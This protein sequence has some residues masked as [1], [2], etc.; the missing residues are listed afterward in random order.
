MKKHALIVLIF[1][2]WA[3]AATAQQE[4]GDTGPE[5]KESL[6]SGFIGPTYNWF[7]RDGNAQADEWGYLHSSAGGDLDAEYD[8]LPQR[9]HIDANYL[10][11]KDYYGETDYAYRDVVL[12][13]AISRG[14]FHNDNHLTNDLT[15]PSPSFTDLNPS[16]QYGD[17]TQLNRASIRLKTP[18]FPFHL[19]ADA[20]T[21]DHSG[22]IQ[23][24]FLR[25]F[26][27]GLN[28]V[29]QSRYIDWRSWEIRVGVNSHLGPVEFDYS[30]MERRLDAGGEQVLYDAYP[31]FT[32]P[33]NQ[34]PD[35]KSSSD[36]VK[37]H[38]DY[39][40]RLV[41][42]VTYS[43]GEKQNLDSG[44]NANTRNMA[45]D[46]TLTP[47]AGLVVVLKYRHYELDQSNPDTV[48][49]PGLGS[50]FA[51]RTPISSK[52]D[53]AT[54]LIRYRFNERLTVKG[55]YTVETID[56]STG[57][58]SILS[59]L[60]VA[61]VP[62]GTAPD[63][64]DVAHHTLKTTENLNVS[65]RVMSKLSL[66]ADFK[67]T[68]V[69]NPAYAD[70]PD[71]ADTANVTVTWTPV[72]RII[73]LASYGGDWEKRSDLTAPLAGGSLETDRDQALGSITFLVDRRTSLTASYMYYRNNVKET[74]TFTDT[75]GSFIQEGAVPYGDTAQV[76]SLA[77]SH[78]PAEGV[79]VTAD[80]SRSYSKGNFRLD[81]TVPGTT[82]IDTL[83]DLYVVEDI[84]TA[85]L[86][87]AFSKNVGSE[88]R[89][90]YRHYDD[91]IDST[92][93]GTVNTVLATLHVKW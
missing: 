15:T 50:T 65:Y 32:V 63:F 1:M 27:G 21:I 86:E 35:L 64:W 84:L 34:V 54:G 82:G 92:Q 9:F 28:E 22:T 4:A 89:Y 11:E 40:G 72:Q 5:S 93:N 80:A 23:Q 56:R 16:D 44:A 81:G 76:F 7:T 43:G 2:L 61:P 55:E 90:Q 25:G 52:S 17:E 78:S 30:H 59:P 70:D 13:N 37:L 26:T 39:T 38:T 69:E 85:G 18:D 12:F 3:S 71:R 91:G 79:F 53:V 29:S 74:L 42:A 36:T 62:A 57:D 10:N 66:R 48:T 47:V 68:Q 83:S 8:P 73:A 33:H 75:S 49:L 14:I 88:F 19:Y 41:A 31:L 46:L 58:G 20:T 51:V 67:A 45:G 87:L 24:I 6:S 77:A 60:Q